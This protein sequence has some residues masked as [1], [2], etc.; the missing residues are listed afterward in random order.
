LNHFEWLQQKISFYNKKKKFFYFPF[1]KNVQKN[2]NFGSINRISK[3][4]N[5]RQN[6]FAKTSDFLNSSIFQQKFQEKSDFL[7]L[8]KQ[9]NI[10]KS[11]IA[12]KKYKKNSNKQKKQELF[13]LNFSKKKKYVLNFLKI[14]LFLFKNKYQRQFF[15]DTKNKFY[16]QKKNFDSKKTKKN[17]KMFSTK[18][19]LYKNIQKFSKNFRKNFSRAFF[20]KRENLSFENIQKLFK[21]DFFVSNSQSGTPKN[22]VVSLDTTQKLQYLHQKNWKIRTQMDSN[23]KKKKNIQIS[24]FLSNQCFTCLPFFMI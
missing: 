1:L 3:E 21:V 13:T 19:V 6:V 8:K 18:I 20:Q 4:I 11:S 16:D 9:K 12:F 10:Q 15:R 23:V 17:T 24:K 22:S 5:S 7:V 14:Q 2:N